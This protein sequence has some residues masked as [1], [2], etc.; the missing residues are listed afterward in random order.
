MTVSKLKRK[1]RAFEASPIP[2]RLAAARN[3]AKTIKHLKQAIRA[4]RTVR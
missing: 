1:L 4:K 2:N 3:R